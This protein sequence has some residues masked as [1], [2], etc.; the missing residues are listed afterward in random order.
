LIDTRND[1]NFGKTPT[2]MKTIIVP[3]DFS[4]NSM[5]A[6]RFAMASAIASKGKVHVIHQTSILELAPDSAFTGLYIPS[7][8]DHLGF[9][10]KELSKFVKKAVTSFKG[11]FD[12]KNIKSE[13]V[14]G[15][16]TADIL[17]QATKRLKGDIIIMGTTGASGLKRLFIGSVAAQ[18][19]E[20]AHVPVIVIPSSFRQK[21]IKKIGYS[22]DL[23]HIVPELEE[24]IPIAKALGATIEMFHIEPT[25]PT[26][27]AFLKF[28]PEIEIPSLQKKLKLESLTFKLI[29]T[30]EDND[31][32]GGIG[33][34]HRT[35]KPD[36][37]CTV[38]HR[39]N[40]VSKILDP[41][42][43]KALAYHNEIPVLSIK[44]K[45]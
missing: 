16:G 10:D 31:F 43:T 27:K 18:I 9:L 5:K 34:Y 12:V 39:R 8:T 42:K 28:Q 36:M 38:R 17:I 13:I 11:K 20:K 44:A 32:F 2:L 40:W 30:K 35:R 7:E 45:Q 14:P 33:K 26:S 15:V 24:I 1:C 19:I 29:K 4:A 6:L 25:F 21:P 23:E 37:I 41:S 22:S 3:T